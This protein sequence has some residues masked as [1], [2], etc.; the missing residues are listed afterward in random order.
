VVGEEGEGYVHCLVYRVY[1]HAGV[2]LRQG[3]AGACHG[4]ERLLVDIR[5]L[6]ARDVVLERHDLRTRLLQLVLVLL[7]AAQGCLGRRLVGRHEFPCQRI[8]LVHLVLQVL[9]TLGQHLQLPPHL[10]DRLLRRL[11]LRCGAAAKPAESPARHG[12][13]RL[14]ASVSGAREQR[15]VGLGCGA[16]GWRGGRGERGGWWAA[17]GLWLRQMQEGLLEGVRV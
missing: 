10:Q 7:L 8:L 13:V 5:A 17:V 16:T 15:R 4:A 3:L 2:Y 14:R 12:E 6:D 11:L 1:G 9:L